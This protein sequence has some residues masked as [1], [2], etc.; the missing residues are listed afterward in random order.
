MWST[1]V[2]WLFSCRPVANSACS[3]KNTCFVFH[4]KSLLVSRSSFMF[5]A[6]ISFPFVTDLKVSTRRISKWASTS[7]GC[8]HSVAAARRPTTAKH[9]VAKEKIRFARDVQL[10]IA[11]E[12]NTQAPT[13]AHDV[14][15]HHHHRRLQP[16]P[17]T[18]AAPPPNVEFLLSIRREDTPRGCGG[19]ADERRRTHGGGRADAC[20]VVEW[21]RGSERNEEHARRCVHDH[22]F[23]RFGRHQEVGELDPCMTCSSSNEN[24]CGSTCDLE[25]TTI[26]TSHNR[27]AGSTKHA[28]DP[29]ARKVATVTM[30][31]A[32]EGPRP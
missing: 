3:Q 21:T 7:F 17:T 16:F 20:D 31:E 11:I 13:C 10:C 32:C 1:N 4:E 23:L 8:H 2:T 29:C 25:P 12:S 14:Q 26:P 24:A 15:L 5:N 18:R 6:S 27:M 28:Y 30:A 22:S 19:N 9:E